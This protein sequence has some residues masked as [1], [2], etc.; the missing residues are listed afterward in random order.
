MKIRFFLYLFVFAVGHGVN[1][2]AG[3]A[4]GTCH[5]AVAAASPRRAHFW[6]DMQGN[7][8]LR[9]DRS[10]LANGVW[11]MDCANCAFCANCASEGG[12]GLRRHY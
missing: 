12:F 3:C 5:R 9:G 6:M 8:I 1:G 11:S 2:C 4:G 7:L 10:L